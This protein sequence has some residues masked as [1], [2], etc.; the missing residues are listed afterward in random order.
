MDRTSLGKGVNCS[1]HESVYFVWPVLGGSMG[2]KCAGD[3]LR[4][5]EYNADRIELEGQC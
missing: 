1:G 2:P 4:A 3:C 5:M